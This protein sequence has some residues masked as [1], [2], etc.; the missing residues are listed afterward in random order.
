MPILSAA[1]PSASGTIAPPTTAV[2][3]NPDPLLVNGP[4][5]AIP[6]AKMFG[7]MI[8]LKNPQSTMLQIATC[9]LDSMETMI[10]ADAAN[11]KVPSSLPD[12]IFVSIHDP[13]KRPT[14]APPQ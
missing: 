5:P 2:M 11:P 6:S 8:E 1:A 4:S 7:N 9:P 13:S 3:I 14:S 10:S 12:L